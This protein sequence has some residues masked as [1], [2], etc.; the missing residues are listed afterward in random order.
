MRRTLLVLLVLAGVVTVA[1]AEPVMAPDPGPERLAAG[2]PVRGGALTGY[3]IRSSALVTADGREVSRT[4]FDPAGWVPVPARSTVF[5]GLLGTGAFPDPF[6]STNMAAVDASAFAVPWW[7]RSDFTVDPGAG[8][9]T[10]VEV[11]GVVSRADVWVNG[12][13]VGTV[14][15]MYPT[16]EFDLSALV[17]PGTNTIAF[18]VAPNDPTRDL[19][20]GWIDWNPA[21]PDNNMGLVGD[22]TIRQSGPVALRGARV[23]TRLALPELDT[24]DL[25]VRVEARND[26][27]SPVVATLSGYAGPAALRATVTLAPFE[28]RTV[29]F[30]PSTLHRPRVWWPVGMGRQPR[31]ELAVDADVAGRRSDGTRDRFGVRRVSSTVD[32]DDIRH[33]AVNG[34]PVAIRGA[35][36]SPDLFLRRNPTRLA[37][38]LASAVDLGL[39]TLRLEGRLGDEDLYEEAD[40][41]GLLLLPGWECCGRWEDPG[42]WTGEDHA[43]AR[44]SM[45][46]VAARLRNHPSVLSFLIGSDLAPPE[47]VETEYLAALRAVDW[48]TPVLSSASGVASPRS[49]PPGL[50][51][52]GP[53]DWVPPGYWYDKRDGGAYGLNAETSAGAALPSMDS[54]RRMLSPE[55]LERLWREPDA[56]VYRSGTLGFADLAIFNGALAGRYGPPTDLADYVA[57]AHLAQFE[58]ARA[59]FEAYA[60]NAADDT[61]PATGQIY[62][63][64][65]SGWPSVHWQLFDSYLDPTA[66]YYA[67]KRTHEPLHVQYSYD[68]RSVVLIRR[69]SREV[70]GL[71]V[72]AELSAPDGRPLGDRTFEDVT[73]GAGNRGGV[74]GV[75][76]L[77][78]VPV[79]EGSGAYLLRLVVTDARGVER[80][81]NVYWLSTGADVLDYAATSYITTP[82]TAYAD[83]TGLATMPRAEVSTT[84]SERRV[85]GA[86]V[87][88]VTVR[89]TSAVPALQVEAR[90]VTADGQPV[91]PV[92]WDDNLVPLWP[93]E[94][95]TLTA[96]H[97]SPS[98]TTVR[99]TG[100]NL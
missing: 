5:G 39:N 94:S 47:R 11:T 44:A 34:R 36:W 61:L 72:R 38:Q 70:A 28:S 12:T 83:L 99:V 95:V 85:D 80:S 90:L 50:K 21:P 89:N 4:G 76:R 87:T 18:L 92:R 27:A 17:R 67:V 13:Q 15:G 14:V 59:Q 29:T 20:T 77:G 86:Y 46:G 74:A 75:T 82:T 84:S 8:E 33:Y 55:E 23:L 35:G 65:T 45:V 52:T 81:R 73:A 68:D 69:G 24:A 64:L 6:Y 79:P 26:S 62:W 1:R 9:H 96:T 56:P 10:F 54:L 91:L 100:W 3:Q 2:A 49:G 51:M 53:Y 57:K 63:S 42:S 48:P 7:F 22:V 88:T 66:G 31:Y 16:Y 58:A 19:T 71:T 97:H 93:G 40:R 37:E 43:V 60:R 41:L 32:A 98:W 30:R 25:T 78:A